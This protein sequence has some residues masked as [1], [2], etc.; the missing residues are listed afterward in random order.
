MNMKIVFL[1]STNG[2]VLN[3]LLK[4]SLVRELTDAVLCDRTCGSLQ[5]SEDYHVKSILLQ[6]SSGKEFSK[7]IENLYSEDNV[8]FISFYTKLLSKEF[9]SKHKG[10]VFNCHPT[11]LPSFKGLHGEEKNLESNYLFMG[12][13]LHEV[14]EFIDNGKP[15]IQ[16]AMPIDINL[17]KMQNRHKIF[18]AQVYSTL[19][20]IYWIKTQKIIFND[21]G[22]E[23]I[24]I[25]RSVDIFNPNLD[26]NFFKKFGYKNELI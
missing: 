26:K 12:C 14:D 17:N 13:T 1:C 24:N 25:Q 10:R 8:V 19:Q 7:K 11:L 3:E 22:W 20:F 18:L 21:I 4:H 9:L 23:L 2:S 16:A 5:V 15:V 6:S